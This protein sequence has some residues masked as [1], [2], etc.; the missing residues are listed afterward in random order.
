MA[1]VY[2]SDPIVWDE[3]EHE[4]FAALG[5]AVEDY[6]NAPA[7]KHP[8]D[9]MVS[10]AHSFDDQSQDCLMGE[11]HGECQIRTMACLDC[12]SWSPTCA[13]THVYPW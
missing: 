12:G 11:C 10:N 4:T 13:A 1:H 5:E 3:P 9:E 6:L 2:L 7:G 8:F